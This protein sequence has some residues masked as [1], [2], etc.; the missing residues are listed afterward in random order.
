MQA[1]LLAFVL[2]A[3]GWLFAT[4]SAFAPTAFG[5]DFVAFYC[6]ASVAASG[7]DPYRV[8]PLRSCEHR[9]GRQFR[10]DS[11]LVVP[12]PLPSYAFAFLE[13]LTRL[14]YSIALAL[15][16]AL[17]IAAYAVCVVMLVRFSGLSPP[18]VIAATALSVG[19][20]S[21]F[22]GQLVPIALAA[23]CLAARAVERERWYA[24]AACCALAAIEPQLALPA[25]AALFIARPA[26]RIPLAAVA[27]GL[28]GL[29]IVVLGIATNVEYLTQV[30]HAQ[31]AS[32]IARSDQL[33]PLAIAYRLGL[34][35]TAAASLGNLTYLLATALGVAFAI[36][37][38]RR[39]GSRATLLFIPPAIALLGMPYIHAHHLAAAIPA[40]LL[41]A[42]KTDWKAPAIVAVFCLAIPWVVP[43][44]QTPLL[45][46]AA[47]IVATLAAGLLRLTPLRAA[48][49][50]CA[51]FA[52][53][54][55]AQS[56]RIAPIPPPTSAYAAVN[57][58]E[59]A[60]AS[61]NVLIGASFH[62][63]AALLTILA[64]PAWAALIALA[65]AAVRALSGATDSGSR[66]PARSRSAAAPG[67]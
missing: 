40:A 55:G 15:W 11:K 46:F 13:P 35:A 17:L 54:L 50:G 47:L 58:G 53:M 66:V 7:A 62:D 12:A 9:N 3:A 33:S 52:L 26:A 37:V 38:E 57:G 21:L 61:W 25:I 43:Y 67:A 51:T 56:L 18:I 16:T 27:C 41:L 31:V 4:R 10:P 19:F 30:V 5:Y 63:N 1:G 14:P 65:L 45:P 28:A 48:A 34:S 2:F 20:V 39:T 23:L 6:G 36:V 32:E 24:A 64:I 29:S 59:L 42:G 22:L 44:D 49:L 60:Q 8:E